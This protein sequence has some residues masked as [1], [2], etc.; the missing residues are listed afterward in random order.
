[1]P[2]ASK[3]SNKYKGIDLSQ[4]WS[5]S[6]S[7]EVAKQYIDYRTSARPTGL[8]KT[9]SQ[10]VFDK[11]METIVR[12]MNLGLF[13]DPQHVLETYIDDG[14]IGFEYTYQ[15]AARRAETHLRNAPPRV[16]REKRV[17]TR[18]RTIQQDLEDRSWAK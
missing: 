8:G 2:K 3:K 4:I 16:E 12:C 7:E 13:R 6:V 15:R 1:M 14:W 10:R 9:I 18:D 11:S 5:Y 17:S